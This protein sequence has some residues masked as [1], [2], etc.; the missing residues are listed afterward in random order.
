MS[1][2]D[3]FIK[4]PNALRSKQLELSLQRIRDAGFE[5]EAELLKSEIEQLRQRAG[6]VYD[7]VE[8]VFSDNLKRKKQP[9]SAATARHLGLEEYKNQLR[10]WAVNMYCRDRAEA[11]NHG[12]SVRSK[13]E[14]KNNAADWLLELYEKD[15]AFE[16]EPKGEPVDAEMGNLF[17][18]PQ[19]PENRSFQPKK[20][21]FYE[22][23]KEKS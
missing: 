9:R 11:E 12:R 23:I 1:K 22:A 7:S 2:R 8:P 5:E 15:R 10:H 19:P 4:G 18:S 21:F 3:E 6:A 13:R 14:G 17:G 16:R 20:N